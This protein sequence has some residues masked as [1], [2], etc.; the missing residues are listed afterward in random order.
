MEERK[1]NNP[2]RIVLTIATFFLAWAMLAVAA[3][4]ICYYFGVDIQS[5]QRISSF[6]G[7]AVILSAAVL[8]MWDWRR[9]R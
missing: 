8:T 6:L 4:L 2:Q 3:R 1:Q 5:D 9:N 7:V